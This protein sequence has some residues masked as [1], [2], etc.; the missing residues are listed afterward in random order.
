MDLSKCHLASQDQGLIMLDA[1]VLV[2]V[3]LT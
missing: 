2:P 3:S 1:S